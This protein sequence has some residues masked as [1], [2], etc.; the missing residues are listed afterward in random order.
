[1]YIEQWK[2]RQNNITVFVI[3]LVKKSRKRDLKNGAVSS[4]HLIFGKSE[5][6]QSCSIQNIAPDLSSIWNIIKI[7]CMNNIGI[8]D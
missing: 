4:K 1:M 8:Y 3:L 6:N 7:H 5:L 2:E